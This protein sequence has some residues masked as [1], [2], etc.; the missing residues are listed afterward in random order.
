MQ[1]LS[2]TTRILKAKHWGN[3][4]NHSFQ[5]DFRK[6]FALNTAP[7]VERKAK[8]CKHIPTKR[9]SIDKIKQKKH[10]MA[11]QLRGLDFLVYL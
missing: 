7:L 8:I 4:V 3:F 11:G 2:D 9:I 10:A 1:D 5:L 6:T